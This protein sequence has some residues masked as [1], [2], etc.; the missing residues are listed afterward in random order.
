MNTAKNSLLPRW[1]VYA[2]SATFF[3]SIFFVSTVA[4]FTV[5]AYITAPLNPLGNETAVSPGN[6][7]TPPVDEDGVSG[8]PAPIVETL[9]PTEQA[10]VAQTVESFTATLP[11]SDRIT[12]LVM[13][14]DR[15]PGE[16]F[17]SRTDT[18]ML[19][20]LN[21]KTEQASILSIPRD[22]Y[23][24]IPGWG[25]D[26][27]NTAFVRGAAA[28]GPAG[29]ADLAMKT[30]SL[31]LGVHVDHYLLID[32]SAFVT[33]IDTLG[34]ID[35]YVPTTINDPTFPNMNYGYDP[36]Y[37]SAGDHVFDGVTALKYARTRHQD[38]DFGRAERQQAVVLAVR[39]K[40][41]SLGAE[42]LLIKMPLLYRQVE[43]GVR[44]DMSLSEMIALAAAGTRL[45][46]ENI[47][48]DVIDY[49]YVI[50]YTTPQ[51][52]SVLVLQ[53]NLAGP[54]IDELFEE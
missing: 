26:R 18:M 13:G 24:E 36:L 5:E 2:L 40:V 39:D 37:I 35:I 45:S 14:I 48:T 4:Y 1:L 16:P 3:T 46:S 15:R 6:D 32:F 8:E 47:K 30:V 44:T 28:G 19:L 43:E 42:E 53:N 10:E 50:S 34:G 12:I 54:L 23:A 20:S 52:A 11:D 29:G 31:N 22:L 7:E 51:G 9:S 41:L 17:V 21:P 25:R 33:G 49:R 27:I 38:N